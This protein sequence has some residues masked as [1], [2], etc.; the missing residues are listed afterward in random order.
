MDAD[1]HY[2]TVGIKVDAPIS[3][4]TILLSTDCD[5]L[6]IQSDT[7]P[8]DGYFDVLPESNTSPE[9]REA[10]LTLTSQADGSAFVLSL[11]QKGSVGYNDDASSD[12]KLGRGFSCFDE[13]MS[14]NSVR[15]TV[16]SEAK[17]RAL[18][19]DST[20]ISIQEAVRGEIYYEFVSAYSMS[21]MQKTLTEKSNVSINFL[22]F[23][24]TVERYKKVSTAETNEQFYGYA[25]MLKT[26][27]SC[28]MDEGALKYVLNNKDMIENHNLPFD[29]DFYLYYDSI[30]ASTGLLRTAL[31]ERMIQM[32]GTHIV[33]QASLGGAI[34]LVTTFSRNLSSSLEEATET[35]FKNTTGTKSSSNFSQ[36]LLSSLNGASAINISGGD[37]LAREALANDVKNLTGDNSLSDT[38]W[39]QWLSSI[40]YASVFD[41]EKR[42]NLGAVNFSFIPIWDLFADKE[43]RVEILSAVVALAESQKNIF[44]DKELGIDNYELTLTKEMMEF[45]SKNTISLVRVLCVNDVPVAEVCNEYVPSIRSD[46]RITVIYPIVNGITRITMGLFPGDGENRPAYL[47]FSDGSVYVD[48]LDGYSS[49]VKLDKIYCLHGSLYPSDMGIPTRD[50]QFAIKEHYL[51][52]E[53]GSNKYPVVKIGSGYWTRTNIKE[54]MHWGYYDKKN[55]FREVDKLVNGQEFALVYYTQKNTFMATNKDIYSHL[56]NSFGHRDKWYVP[57]TTD[58]G[59]LTTF[60]GRNHKS[61]FMGQQSGFDAQFVGKCTNKDP[62]TGNNLSNLLQLEKDKKCYILFKD[63]TPEQNAST[64][65]NATILSLNPDYTWESVLEEDIKSYYYPIRCFRTNHYNYKYSKI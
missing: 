15:K 3:V 21:E 6:S 63:V 52:F 4:N 62:I 26:V 18:D 30:N 33:V 64:V 55:K 19:S 60:L 44:S 43:V 5:W 56:P 35:V 29:D 58:M 37:S 27:A 49:S 10:K 14:V 39:N 48:P 41:T 8:S 13:Y 65:T 31:I 24:K 25:R 51:Q 2:N 45:D 7:L 50:A 57:R 34:D 20:F 32:Y 59:H 23:K 11:I 22:G 17:L 46:K 47:T 42:K 36:S 53:N 12:Y 61:M 38:L 40:T 9:D 16:I 28:S 54:Y 1:K